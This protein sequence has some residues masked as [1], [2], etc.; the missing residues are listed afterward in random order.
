MPKFLEGIRVLD[1]T[2]IL[3]GPFAT[4]LLA[5]AGAEVVKVE[6]PKSG[7]P[8]RHWGPPFIE[9]ESI[10]FAAFNR[11][12]HSVELDLKKTEDLNRLRDLACTAD[13]IVENIRPGSLEKHGLAYRDLCKLN[14]RLI[15]VSIRG[16]S[17]HSTR[18]NDPGLE[19]IM[20][21]ESGLMSITG[22]GEGGDPVRLGVAAIDMM[23]GVFA[24]SWI[25]SL[26]YQRERTGQG[27]YA[28]V[29]LEE[30]TALMMTHPWLMYLKAGMDY[31]ASGTAHPSIAPYEVFRTQD[32][33]LMLGAVDD[34]Q[35]ERLAHLLGVSDW[36][37]RPEW[38]TNSQRVENRLQ[39][40]QAI[41]EHLLTNTAEYWREKLAEAKLP[42]GIV[43]PVSSAAK[44]WSESQMPRLHANHPTL[45]ALEWPGSPGMSR[46]GEVCPPPLLGDWNELVFRK[47]FTT[48]RG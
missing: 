22:P 21:A 40:H 4:M 15:Y 47:W 6:R 12:K 30:T 35:F 11:G 20:E 24:V 16:Y 9:D 19:V 26:L 48:G 37:Q 7:D 34:A 1:F 32:K 31:K 41:E 44:Q 27:G 25:Y 13:V 36:L 5:D 33:R 17:E 14:P 46:D 39:L 38:A 45:G 43:E 3:S 18:A 28:A 23:T 42:V 29:S 2:Q 10:Y 8:T